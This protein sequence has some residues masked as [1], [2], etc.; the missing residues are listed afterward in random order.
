MCAAIIWTVGAGPKTP[1]L[2]FGSWVGLPAIQG[3]I[4]LP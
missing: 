2:F 3:H 1:T 4:R